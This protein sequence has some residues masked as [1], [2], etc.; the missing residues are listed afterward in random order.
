MNLLGVSEAGVMDRQSGLNGGAAMRKHL[1]T[2]ATVAMLVLPAAGSTSPSPVAPSDQDIR[3]ILQQ[4]IDAFHQG[5]G[6]VVG[7]IDPK[8]RRVVAYGSLDKGDARPLNGATVFEIGSVT[9]VFT[10]LLLMDMVQRGEVN[11]TDPVVKFLPA[12]VRVP[13]RGGKA[14][15]LQDLSNQT[16]GLPRMPGNFAPKDPTNPYADYSPEQLFTFLSSYQ[17]TRDIGSKYEYSN[18]GVGLLGQALS[19]QV[20]TDFD[21]LV[22]TRI[23]GPLGMKSTGVTLSPDTKDRLAVGHDGNLRPVANWDLPTLAGA[24]A[25]RSDVDDMLSFLA[26]HLGY[27]ASKLAPAMAAMLGPRTPTGMPG[28]SIALGWH[29]LDVEGTELIWHNGG[30]GGYRSFVGFNPKTRVGVV[31]LS[32]TSNEAGVDDIGR[33]LLDAR[34]PLMAA[35]KEHREVPMDPKC[36]ESFTGQYQLSPHFVLTI[37]HEGDGL[38]AQATGQPKFQIF[39]EG[40]RDFFLKVVDAQITFQPDVNGKASGLLLHQGGRDMPAKRLGEVPAVTAP[41]HRE[42]PVDPILFDQYIGRYALAPTFILTITREG[43]H[44]FAQATNQPKFEL[45]AESS[46]TFFLK[47]VD[48]QVSFDMGPDGKAAGLTLH[49]NGAHMPAKRMK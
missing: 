34:Q 14:I 41:A 18:L 19:R 28:V 46:H 12:G 3:T 32:N 47:V 36:L 16:S 5:V 23:C 8:G 37:T 6:I 42:I 30:T 15:T 35:P 33:H 11:L 1:L 29:V 31:V 22:R 9:K 39:R 25:L 45:F 20:G 49:Q 2:A 26:A 43:D 17:L 38:F 21:T 44:L 4:R 40:E 24:G 13:Q 10:S 7:V 27:T 48:A